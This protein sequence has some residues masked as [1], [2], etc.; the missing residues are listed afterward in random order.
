MS[1]DTWYFAYGSNLLVDQKEERTGRIRETLLCR[2]PGYRLVFNK[3]S[4][5]DG[6]AR[7]NIIEDRAKEVWGVAYLCDE[8]AMTKMDEYEG[9]AGGH[10]RRQEVQVIIAS[11]RMRLDAMT[12]VAG[13]EFLCPEGEPSSE[14]LDQILEG[15]RKQGLPDDYIEQ[16][17]LLARRHDHSG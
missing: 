10:Y 5:G 6:T 3:R 13:E 12:Y 15:A 2:L 16:I 1:K 8:A 9:V 4:H 14:Y 11:V 7:A 17:D